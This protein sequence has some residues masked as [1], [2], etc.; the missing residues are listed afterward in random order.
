[1]RL[2]TNLGSVDFRVLLSRFCILFWGVISTCVYDPP[3][4]NA[5]SAKIIPKIDE[6]LVCGQSL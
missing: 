5:K 6:P 4:K 1:M 2:S 3:K